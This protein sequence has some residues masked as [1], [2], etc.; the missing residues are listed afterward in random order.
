MAQRG[1]IRSGKGGKLRVLTFA[2]NNEM[3]ADSQ[4]VS[5][6]QQAKKNLVAQYH[7]FLSNPIIVLPDGSKVRLLD[8]VEEVDEASHNQEA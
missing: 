7:F 3:L 1:E 6:L 2:G 4:R 8:I 5:G